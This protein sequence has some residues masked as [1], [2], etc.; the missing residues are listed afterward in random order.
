MAVWTL[1]H[2]AWPPARAQVHSPCSACVTAPSICSPAYRTGPSLP[3]LGPVV[4]TG[5]WVGMG[6]PLDSSLG[7]DP[8]LR[9]QT[10]TTKEVVLELASLSDWRGSET[11]P[12]LNGNPCRNLSVHKQTLGD[13]APWAERLGVVLERPGFL[14]RILPCDTYVPS[15]WS[16]LCAWGSS[17]LK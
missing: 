10:R 13:S 2:N 9:D 7:L 8:L 16:L 6:V 14:L 3:I 12:S 17:F 4:R 5:G 15:E 11:W 1:V